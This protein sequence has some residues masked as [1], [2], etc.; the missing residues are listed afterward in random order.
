MNEPTGY[1]QPESAEEGS[2]DGEEED[3]PF[4]K[5]A[6]SDLHHAMTDKLQYW[7]PYAS[8]TDKPGINRTPASK[9]G[10]K[11]ATSSTAAL[12]GESISEGL[13]ESER[14]G[15]RTRVG[16][17][18]IL[19]NGNSYWERAIRTHEQHD[20]I[21]GYRLHVLRQHLMDDVWSKPAYILSLLLREL[22]KPDSERLDWLFWV[23]ADTV[24]LNPYVPVEV[25]LPPPGPEFEDVN[26]LYSN[27]WNGLNN[28]VFPI[29]VNRWAVDL[30]SAIVSFRYYRPDDPL[31]FRDQSAMN[32][33]M[34]EPKFKKGVVAAPQRWFN[35]YQG[36]HNETLA[37]FQIR[38]GDLL[39]HFAGVPNREERMGY[40]L[41]RAE[42][43]LDDW[44]VPLKSTSYPQERADFWN[45]YKES[46]KNWRST[47][48]E[49]R[50]KASQAM[51][52]IAEQM[53][54]FGD[55][56]TDEQKSRLE[57]ARQEMVQVLGDERLSDDMGKLNEKIDAMQL[58]ADP[59]T[60]N[61]K[62]AQK[63]LLISAHEAILAGEREALAYQATD[64]QG[65]LE[66]NAV[67]NAI[68]NLKELIMAPQEQW[69]KPSILAATNAV[70]EARARMQEKSDLEKAEQSAA[71]EIQQAKAALERQTAHKAVTGADDDDEDDEANASGMPVQDA[72][73]LP[74]AGQH[75]PVAAVVVTAQMPATTLTQIATVIGE[76]VI[77]TVTGPAVVHT[78]IQDAVVAT[79]WTSVQD[80]A[81]AA[82]DTGNGL[83]R[84]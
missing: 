77:A 33:I 78:I 25:F 41:E 63:L 48:A 61:I 64:G 21:H 4:M 32:T 18:T 72:G 20:R 81:P 5:G 13:P 24:I 73:V 55:R 49:N 56:L 15:A 66:F 71:I 57:S 8:K 29:R 47:V 22:A 28:G 68:Q 27:D 69:H 1:G 9:T 17:C 43:H 23:D 46:K 44:E 74:V 79:L 11:A 60:D 3:G 83:G 54:D 65:V 53:Q 7:N 52:K 45:E 40:W 26:L 80:E 50:Q 12:G 10:S 75:G 70:T 67:N 36:E 84:R 14:L 6:L 16:K 2:E 62:N 58:A 37:P 39:V 38:R 30:F 19:F 42:Q 31:V 35:A 82:T 59:L 76:A 34:N 51:S